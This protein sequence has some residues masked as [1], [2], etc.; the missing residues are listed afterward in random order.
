MWREIRR[1]GLGDAFRWSVIDR[2]PDHPG[3]IHAVAKRIREG[4]QEYPEA[5]RSQ[6]ALVFSA[7]SIPMRIVNRGDPYPQVPPAPRAPLTLPGRRAHTARALR[8]A[9]PGGG[10]HGSARDASAGLQQPLRPRLAVAG[11]VL[12]ARC[13]PC[14]APIRLPRPA[15][16]G[17]CRGWG[18]RRARCSTDWASRVTSARAVRCRACAAALTLNRTRRQVRHG[19][20]HRLHIGPH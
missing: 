19:G 7:H 4:L 8:L 17:T 2:W 3:F 16:W 6:V 1:L 13:S 14:R 15:Q 12:A 11:Y 9:V 10:E 18:R 20:A 5:V